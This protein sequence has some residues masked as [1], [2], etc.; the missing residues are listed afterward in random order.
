MLFEPG[1]PLELVELQLPPLQPGQ[2]LVEIAY[3]GVCHSQLNEV[4]GRK[5][6]DRYLPHVMGHEGSGRVLAVGAAVR[7]VETGDHVV[8]TWIKGGGAD[9]AS[10]RYESARGPINSG[11]IAT[12]MAHTVT[13]ESR[14]VRLTPDFPLRTATLLGCAIPTGGGIV[15]HTGDVQPGRSVAIFGVGGV[16]AAAIAVA[17]SAGASPLIALDIVPEKLE[18]ARRLGA[19]HT[20]DARQPTVAQQLRELTGGGVDLA[21]EAAGLPP[22]ME[23]AFSSVHP[24]GGLCVIAGNVAHG[25]TIRLDPF[26]LIKGRRIVGSWGGETDPDTDIPRYA[27]MAL[28]GKLNLDDMI[29]HEFALPDINR[30]LDALEV[31]KVARAIV[32]FDH[33]AA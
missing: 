6:P 15:L 3:S 11:A 20:L 16:G 7:K 25:E 5:G 30:A 26:D 9:V 8:L 22:V 21:V 32:K 4:R 13:C 19:T 28:A 31:G 1:R 10:V 12:F 23:S 2:V 17:A 18:F 14:L 27:R 24:G 29:S 33:G